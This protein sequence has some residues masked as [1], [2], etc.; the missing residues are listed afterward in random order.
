[1]H[2]EMLVSHFRP[3]IFVKI[4]ELILD[5]KQPKPD[6]TRE[7]QHHCKQQKPRH[8]E[9]LEML[10]GGAGGRGMGNGSAKDYQRA[11]LIENVPAIS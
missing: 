7:H 5:F 9:G 6:A 2:D 11:G 8:R 4:R 10:H 3:D 1:M